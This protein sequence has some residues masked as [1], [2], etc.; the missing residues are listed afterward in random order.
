MQEKD[1]KSI[2]IIDLEIKRIERV[3]NGL[4]NSKGSQGLIDEY[5][6]LLY[7]KE[8]DLIAKKI[9]LE[10]YIATIDD[11]EIRLILTL[12]FIDLKSWNY[13]SKKL[14]YDRTTVYKKFKAFISQ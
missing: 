14:H 13:I 9:A 3:L 11:A 8:N 7:S 4:N 2:K 1:L 6:I 10:K 12:R 5:T